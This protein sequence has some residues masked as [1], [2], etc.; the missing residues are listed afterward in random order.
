M[1]KKKH[2]Y[3]IHSN[4]ILNNGVKKYYPVGH[5]FKVLTEVLMNSN[6]NI[7]L[8]IVTKYVA[9]DDSM[10]ICLKGKT[11]EV[12]SLMNSFY[13]KFHKEY[14]ICKETSWSI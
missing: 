5:A 10:S 6:T 7:E 1:F 3:S 4:T 8:S 2:Y 14:S 13:S 12:E 9:Y 11:R